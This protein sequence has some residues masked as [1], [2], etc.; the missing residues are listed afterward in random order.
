MG[1]LAAL[2][3]LSH[4][5]DNGASSLFQSHAGVKQPVPSLEPNS[6][7]YSKWSPVPLR[8]RE[9]GSGDWPG[10]SCSKHFLWCLINERQH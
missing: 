8:V 10:I 9:E 3:W 1:A 6:R 4:V 2:S 5:T 7:F